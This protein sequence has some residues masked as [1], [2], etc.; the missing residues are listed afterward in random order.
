MTGRYPTNGEMRE[1]IASGGVS[2]G[3][4]FEIFGA[5]QADARGDTCGWRMASSQ[6]SIFVAN[7]FFLFNRT[8]L[9]RHPRLC[10]EWTDKCPPLYE[11]NLPSSPNQ[12][13]SMS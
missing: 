10:A 1:A 2:A 5:G 12:S 7:T 11:A 3:A 13:D 6:F 4:A 9:L 8:I